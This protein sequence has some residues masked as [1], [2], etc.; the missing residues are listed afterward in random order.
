MWA[1]NSGTDATTDTSTAA[2]IV[3]I[4]RIRREKI[5]ADLEALCEEIRRLSAHADKESLVRSFTEPIKPKTGPITA[6]LEVL[7]YCAWQL[8]A[9]VRARNRRPLGA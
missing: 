2:P 4:N 9:I 1:D 5:D 8:L 3:V 7:A 6:S